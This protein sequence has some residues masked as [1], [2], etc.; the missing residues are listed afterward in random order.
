MPYIGAR[1][2]LQRRV[3]AEDLS[4]GTCAVWD[5]SVRWRETGRESEHTKPGQRARRLAVERNAVEE[6]YRQEKDRR[7]GYDEEEPTHERLN[8]V[9]RRYD[10]TLYARSYNVARYNVASGITP[11]A[12][13]TRLPRRWP[14]PARSSRPPPRRALPL[15]PS[16][17]ARQPRAAG[18]GRTRTAQRRQMSPRTRR[19]RFRRPG[20]GFRP[21]H[22]P[23]L[24]TARPNRLDASRHIFGRAG[25]RATTRAA[26][27]RR[28]VPSRARWCQARWSGSPSTMRSRPR[29]GP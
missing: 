24:P 2:P 18:R 7:R 12:R 28:R 25:T 10:A 19:R 23:D 27:P 26:P 16:R 22:P 6:H 5:G 4:Y 21:R 11:A 13:R 15:R 29:P 3:Y 17:R 1:S 20:W 9:V 14:A 8:T